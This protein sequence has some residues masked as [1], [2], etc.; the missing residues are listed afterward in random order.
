M[1]SVRASI[2]GLHTEFPVAGHRP[3]P[4]PVANF[5][6][7]PTEMEHLTRNV[8]THQVK[9]VLDLALLKA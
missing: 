8:F 4:D 3:R 7:V 2:L 6:R 1:R 9:L 5:A